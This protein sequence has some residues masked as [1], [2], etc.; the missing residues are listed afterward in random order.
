MAI[1]TNN[2]NNNKNKT[3]LCKPS[4][5]YIIVAIIAII[6]KLTT[7]ILL[8]DLIL[9]ILYNIMWVVLLNWLCQKGYSSF[10]WVLVIIPILVVPIATY[11]AKKK[12]TSSSTTDAASETASDTG[13]DPGAESDAESDTD[14]TT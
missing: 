13:T 1:I 4:L 11:Y 2:N 8:V 10:S 6:A 12:N 3:K 7:G 14:T 5:I 9:I